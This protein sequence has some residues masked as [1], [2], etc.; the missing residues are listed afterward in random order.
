MHAR[1]IPRLY[2]HPNTVQPPNT[3]PHT[4]LAFSQTPN[5]AGGASDHAH[6]H[7]YATI[8]RAGAAASPAIDVVM[9]RMSRITTL[10]QER[11]R[12]RQGRQKQ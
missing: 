3:Q 7:T 12:V 2:T 4:E 8:D 1:Y 6:L 11:D 10:T 9:H 5:K